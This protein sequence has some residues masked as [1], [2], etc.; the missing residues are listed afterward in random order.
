MNATQKAISCLLGIVLATLL[1]NSVFAGE[2]A[3]SKRDCDHAWGQERGYG[4]YFDKR[5]SALHT[6]LKLSASQEAA[7][8]E[9]SGKMKPVKMDKPAHQDMTGMSTPDRLDRMLDN[10]KSSEKSM[11]EHAATIRAFYDTLT[12]EQ[13]NVFDMHFQARQNHR[14][15]NKK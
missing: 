10:M 15:R 8:T 1:S 6:A 14:S 4:A 5:M 2:Q 7:W 13:K 12:Q 3:A 11:T 9:F